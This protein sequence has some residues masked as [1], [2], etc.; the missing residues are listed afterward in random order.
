MQLRG[1]RR[2]LEETQPRC[3]VTLDRVTSPAGILVPRVRQA[4]DGRKSGGH[5][6]TDSSRINRRIS[7]L[8]LFHRTTVQNYMVKKHHENLKKLPSTLDTGSHI[9]AALQARRAA[10]ARH[11]RSNCL[12]CQGD[13]VCYALGTSCGCQGV[14]CFTMAFRIV[15]SLRMQAV[16]ATFATFPA[17]RKRS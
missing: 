5:E 8:R 2:A 6:P 16:N 10:G 11:E 9:N 15:N 7:W 14:W 4:P 3:G 12:V 17:A 1:Y 13:P